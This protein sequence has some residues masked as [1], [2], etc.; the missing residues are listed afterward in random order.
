MPRREPIKA[1]MSWQ[2]K[3]YPHTDTLSFRRAA[4]RPCGA[5]GS[6]AFRLAG[7]G[8]RARTAANAASNASTRPSIT[9]T[10]SAMMI[11]EMMLLDT[12]HDREFE[13][14]CRN[15]ATLIPAH[16]NRM[17]AQ[18]RCKHAAL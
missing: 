10:N 11:E 6:P 8:E 15:A 3:S 9:R 7:A 12:T 17:R 2:A 16:S 4:R 5:V 18:L 13:L 1:G 14:G